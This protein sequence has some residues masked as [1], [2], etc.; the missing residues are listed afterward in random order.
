VNV[1]VTHYISLRQPWATLWVLGEKINETRSWPTRHRGW[2]GA[3]ASKTFGDAE[4]DAFYREPFRSVLRRHGISE[5][6]Y[7]PRGALIGAARVSDCLR[8]V[9]AGFCGHQKADDEICIACDPRITEQER[10]F[11]VYEDGRFALTTDDRFVLPSPVYMRA[12]RLIQRIPA[13]VAAIVFPT[14]A[15]PAAKESAEPPVSSIEKER[16]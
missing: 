7:L 11:G 8:M 3:H 2:L 10:A 9:G 13:D 15:A 6:L 1:E 5:P 14:V 16:R 4:R 12:Q